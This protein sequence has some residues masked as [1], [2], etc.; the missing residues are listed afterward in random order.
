MLI[1]KI[2]K[3][4]MAHKLSESYTKKCQHIHGHSYTL[5]VYVEAETTNLEGVVLDYT[6]LKEIVD[7]YIKLLDHNFMLHK[8]D[9][10][11]ED[12]MSKA[13]KET[14]PLIICKHNPTAEFLALMFANSIAYNLLKSHI[15]GIENVKCK[16][17]ETASSSAEYKLFL[18]SA[19]YENTLE[20][21]CIC[22]S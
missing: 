15:E 8:E 20:A 22:I 2:F 1:S 4:E 19:A 11:A 10:V 18:S 3:F 9:K 14:Y 12:L 13:G 21:C 5:E 6:Y 16:I 7:P 17:K